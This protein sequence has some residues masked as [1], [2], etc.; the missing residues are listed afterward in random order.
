MHVSLHCCLEDMIY[1][2]VMVL[3]SENKRLVGVRMAIEDLEVELCVM[4]DVD[5][6]L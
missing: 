2:D 1:Y 6:M 5:E 4:N 3:Q